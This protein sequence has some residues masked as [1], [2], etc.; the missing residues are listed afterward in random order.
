[1]QDL[2]F[3]AV[4]IGVIVLFFFYQ[5]WTSKQHF[6]RS[7]SLMQSDAAT[8]AIDLILIEE[9]KLQEKRLMKNKR[10]KILHGILMDEVKSI[11]A[12]TLK[13]AKEKLP[14]GKSERTIENLDFV[15]IVR[16]NTDLKSS[17][18]ASVKVTVYPKRLLG[19]FMAVEKWVYLK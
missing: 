1:M 10:Y 7:N 18:S 11:E 5:K 6:I 16:L 12:M 17:S 15:M 19:I 2:I 9:E 3:V 8:K 13:Q 4:I 14:C